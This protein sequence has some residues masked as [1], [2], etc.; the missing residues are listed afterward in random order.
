[1][2]QAI[3]LTLLLMACPTVD[4]DPCDDADGDGV[5]DEVVD[6]DLVI[7][8]DDEPDTDSVDTDSECPDADGDGV[9]D[10]DDLCEGSDASG[11]TDGDGTCDDLDGDDDDDGCADADDS[12]P[13]VVS[14]DLDGDGVASD[15]D[16]CAG[17]DV[18]GDLDADG[19]CND[20][21]DDD[22][23]DGCA[24]VDDGAPLVGSADADADGLAD[25]CDPCPDVDGDGWGLP[26][27][28]GCANPAAADCDDAAGNDSDVDGDN[29]CIPDDNCP[30][31][32]NPD[33]VDTDGNGSGDA[34]GVC[35]DDDNDGWGAAGTA[36]GACAEA[37]D[38][39]DDTPGNDSDPDGDNLC[40]SDDN[41]ANHA[42]V[43]QL[44]GDADGIG[45]ACDTCSD[46]DGDGLGAAGSDRSGCDAPAVDCDD[47]LGNASD[48]DGDNVCIPADNCPGVPNPGQADADGDGIG[49]ACVVCT[50]EDGDGYGVAG[51]NGGC[52]QSGDDCDDTPGNSSDDDH[53][54]VCGAAD[55]CPTV[56][57]ADQDDLDGDG[58][59]DACDDCTDAD[60][61]GWA[62]TGGTDAGCAEIG[63]DCD[64][65]AGNTSDP[66]GD[67]LCGTDDNCPVT[68]NPVQDDQNGDGIGDACQ[69]CTDE[70]GDGWGA[71]ATDQSDCPQSGDDCDDTPGN[72]V[73]DDHDNVCGFADNC[74]FAANPD[75]ANNDGDSDGDACDGCTDGDNDGWGVAGSDQS[76]CAE[77][78]DDCDDTP[79]NEADSDEDNACGLDDNCQDFSNISQA[80]AD[81]DGI[82]DACDDC[83]DA[84][85]DGWGA[86][87]TDLFGC[88]E[89]EVDCD[90][91]GE[92]GEDPDFDNICVD[93]NCPLTFN[94]DQSDADSDGPGDVCD[95]CT[96]ADAD[97]WGREALDQST[98]PSPGDDCN[99][100]IANSSD[101]DGD[102]V[103]GGFDN[104]P[105]V[106][107]PDQSNA[108]VDGA[109]DS[110]DACT[111]ADSD[112][113]G[114]AGFDQSGCSHAGDDCDDEA[115]NN[116]DSEMD[117]VCGAADN[118]PFRIN[119]DQSD[120]DGDGE[121]DACDQC[122]DQDGDGWGREGLIYSGCPNNFAD[123]NDE[124]DNV[125]DVDG[126]NW[127]TVDDNCPTVHNV[128][129]FDADADAA[130]DV[131]DTCTDGDFD[132]WGRQGLD[133]STCPEVGDDCDDTPDN[134]SDPLGTNVCIDDS[135]L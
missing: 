90:D 8:T 77:V 19:S 18:Q 129:Q 131:C 135:G 9:C 2:R 121:G 66:D 23:G 81:G 1:M 37:G 117:N 111:D 10:A 122:S 34:C 60:G 96:D 94:A 74:P 89:A 119:T 52:P 46:E 59:G 102:N 88:T 48:L 76:S 28:A 113:W 133:Q 124:T 71:P 35:V 132:G 123:C 29:V 50:D 95:T 47:T 56:E 31:V 80:D 103:C 112:G 4:K 55:S 64:D 67:N 51:E 36:Q 91:L 5:C 42:N 110:C 126:D 134:D 114:R 68:P 130:G 40:G 25:D 14:T 6:T 39:C 78:G 86:A 7:D 33:Q 72:G 16:L 98:C 17:D 83:T 11:D 20:V 115:G 32:A 79:G 44:D 65:A 69:I 97:G 21:D 87:G 26:A 127:C 15:C 107:N 93:D 13:L 30:A 84:D 62:A 109:G 57:N 120:V 101:P 82:G 43:D 63:E 116:S 38:D 75:Q 49:N 125:D 92:D 54:N 45:D 3:W 61:D 108:D 105:T 70:D 99:D 128:E 100:L 22:D 85:D 24:D 27:A 73:D 106:A 104:C 58:V 118:C 12:A 53:D 41:C